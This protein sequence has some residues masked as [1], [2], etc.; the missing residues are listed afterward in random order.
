M[1][2]QGDLKGAW[3]NFAGLILAALIGGI[4][5]ANNKESAPPTRTPAPSQPYPEFYRADDVLTKATSPASPGQQYL[6]I[7]VVDPGGKL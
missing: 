2:G 4:F 7:E 1:S 5:L 3:I 6:H